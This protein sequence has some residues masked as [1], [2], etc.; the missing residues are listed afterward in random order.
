MP[1]RTAIIAATPTCTIRSRDPEPG[2]N[3]PMPCGRA[4]T[5][6][7]AHQRWE[8]GEHGAQLSGE[9][10]GQRYAPE[11]MFFVGSV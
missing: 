5:Y 6:D 2:A 9:I 8:C 3:M 1:S 10:A 11:R 7:L 4:L